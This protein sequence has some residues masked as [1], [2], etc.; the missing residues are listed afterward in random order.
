MRSSLKAYKTVSIDSQLSEASPHKV[1]QMLMA[2]AIERLIQGKTAIQ[3]KHVAMKGERLGRA[4][5]IIVSLRT[6]LSI[7]GSSDIANNLDSLYDFMIRQVIEA[8]QKN[9]TQPIDNVVEML[10]EIKLAWDQIPLEFH[11]L[12]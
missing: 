6:C 3:Q 4:L 7:D 9:E 12:T 11:Y 5:D 1:I 10:K 2:G 8:N